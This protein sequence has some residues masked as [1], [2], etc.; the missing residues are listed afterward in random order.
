[1]LKQFIESSGASESNKRILMDGL[2]LAMQGA[3]QS[4]YGKLIKL[5]T[6][7]RQDEN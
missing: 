7:V 6:E 1:M 4:E 2:F 5:S 3:P